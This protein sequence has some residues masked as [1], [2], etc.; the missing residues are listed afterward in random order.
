MYY[1]SPYIQKGY[2]LGGVF[3]SIA[4]LIHPIARKTIRFVNKPSVRNVLKTIGKEGIDSSKELLLDS[5]Q[6]KDIREKLKERIEIGKKHITDS[7]REGVSSQ[8]NNAKR[9]KKLVE[10]DYDV[11]DNES[12]RRGI[13]E[14]GKSQKREPPVFKTHS[15]KCLM[16]EDLLKPTQKTLRKVISRIKDTKINIPLFLTNLK[17][18]T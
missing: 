1:R 15:K 16:L 6:G 5:L 14:S 3:R 12:F 7:I 13:T 11:N 18:V 4:K 2:G 9:Y 17:I 10:D 8:M